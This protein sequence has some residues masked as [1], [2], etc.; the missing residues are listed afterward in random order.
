MFIHVVKSGESLYTISRSHG[1]SLDLLRSVN[2]LEYTNI[3]PGQALLLPLNVYTV[4]PGD[5]F[6]TIARKAFVTLQQL[7]NAN[8]SI[9][10]STLQPGMKINIPK[11]SKYIAE[12]LGYYVPESPEADRALVNDFGPYLTYIALFEYHFANKGE[13]VNDLNDSVAIQTAWSRR[14]TPL[15]TITNLIPEGFSPELTHQ[16]LNNPTARTNLVN[17]IY[18][19]VTRK[20]YGGVNIDLER[21]QEEDRDL[22]TGFLRQMKDILNP[23]GLLLTIALPAKT[24]EDI[25]W[26]KG[27]DFGGIGAIVDRMFIMAYDWHHAGG[28]PGPTAPILEVR[29]S[30]EYAIGKLNNKKIILG[31]PLYGYNW[32][33]PYSPGIVAT[34]LSSQVA[35]ETAMKYQA[36]IQY[37]VEYQSPFF[38]YYDEQGQQH[39]AW[40]EDVRSMGEKMRLAREYGLQGIGAWQ[41]SLNFPQGVWLLTNFFRIK[42]V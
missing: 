7:R 14:V 16:V 23:A 2:G 39:E 13:I 11:I 42:K 37:S 35:V 29:N 1:I 30:I 18:D 41:L 40:F 21:I 20:G 36:P 12:T 9:N 19:L 28:E 17:N 6:F 25:P 5:T 22:Y 33:I 24:E 34:A 8:P 26:L 4:Q 15:A 27:Y 32:A 38:R 31:V 10:P 3:V